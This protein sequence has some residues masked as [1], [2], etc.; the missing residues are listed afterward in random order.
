[1]RA[2]GQRAKVLLHCRRF[3]EPSYAS[4]LAADYQFYREI[5]GEADLR[6]WL[7]AASAKS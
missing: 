3:A 5:D 2:P 7:G 6:D 1:V 4:L